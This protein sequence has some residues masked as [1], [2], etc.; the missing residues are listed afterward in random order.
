MIEDSKE[1]D[2]ADSTINHAK[3]W[4]DSAEPLAAE[5][6]A[7]EKIAIDDFVKVDLRIARI[8]D[9]KEVPEARKL[10]QLTLSLGG[11]ERRNVF[12]GIKSAYKAEDLIG[13]L[14][15]CAAN[16]EPRQMKFGLSEGMVVAAGPGGSDIFLLS[17]DPGAKPGMR[18]H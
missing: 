16:L 18:L 14:V 7:E 8:I 15:V 2:A 1:T 9:A 13:R 4:D 5:P 3:T 12:A 17:P 10:L 6:L 11:D